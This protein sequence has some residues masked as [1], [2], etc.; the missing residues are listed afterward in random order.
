MILTIELVSINRVEI[1]FIIISVV[2]IE[3][4]SHIDK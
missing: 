4:H 2:Q 1:R 3:R